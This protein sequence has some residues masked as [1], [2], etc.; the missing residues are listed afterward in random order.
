MNNARSN[1]NKK[2]GRN[3]NSKI[4]D[5]AKKKQ[6][7]LVTKNVGES[8]LFGNDLDLFDNSSKRESVSEKIDVSKKIESSESRFDKTE[9][10]EFDFIDDDYV[11]NKHVSDDIE[12]LEDMGDNKKTKNTKGGKNKKTDNSK[13]DIEAFFKSLLRNK[14]F[15]LILLVSF[16]TFVLGFAFCFSFTSKEPEVVTKIEEKI[17]NDENIVFLGDSIF[18]LYDVN[19]YFKDKHV[20]NSGV[21]GHRTTTVLKDLES[22]VYRYNPSVVFIMIGTNDM[23]DNLSNEE[24]ISNVGKIVDGI[25]KNRP[26]AVI[27]VISLFPVNT[28]N[29]SKVVHEMVRTRNNKDI[30]IMNKGIKKMCKEKKVTYIDVNSL[31]L[32]Q[33]NCLDI[34]YTTDGLHVN[35]DAYKI[36]TEKLNSYLQ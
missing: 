34:N 21:S 29:D 14:S 33:N 8:F 6:N 30:N 20:V 32:D 12:I 22:R 17:V 10:L 31:L 5:K 11:F 19:E 35:S 18:E 36:I 15:M 13:N 27:N 26:S 28:S 3:N 1:F 23:L 16:C 9:V 7:S 4:N 2:S 25:K 24:T